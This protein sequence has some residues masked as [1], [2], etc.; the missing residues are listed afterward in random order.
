MK[1]YKRVSKISTQLECSRMGHERVGLLPKTLKWRELVRQIASMYDSSID[2]S[3]IARQTIKNVRSR[4]RNISQDEG[5]KAAFQ[6]LVTLSIASRADNPRKILFD[7]GIDLSEKV[8][9]FSL[10]KAVRVWVNPRRRSVEYGEI[11]QSAAIDSI[12]IWYRKHNFNQ[13]K[14]FNME[15]DSFEV[16]RKAGTGAGF[17]ELARIFFA[18][19][20]ERYLNYFLEREATA[21]LRNMEERDLFR[22]QLQ[23]YMENISQHAF[24]TAKI[25]Q[26]FAAGWFNK[27]TKEGFPNTK[28]IEGFL[29]LA[30]GKIRDELLREGEK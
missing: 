29:T 24:E 3:D 11:A 25:T 14:L 30:F 28:E 6:F 4:L 20:T 18:K 21:A 15:E 22:S 2:I 9:P 1:R 12:A 19:F 27:N 16:W 26:S 13:L 8:T 5:V 10:A 7:V 17:C 23:D